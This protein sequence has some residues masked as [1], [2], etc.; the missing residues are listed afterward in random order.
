MVHMT[1]VV[2]RH[3]GWCPNARAFPAP[4]KDMERV[5]DTGS[6]SPGDIPAGG[7][8]GWIGRHGQTSVAITAGLCLF[9]LAVVLKNILVVPADVLNR[10]M[11][12][13]I[14]LYSG[15]IACFLPV[16]DQADPGMPGR[17]PLVWC[18]VAIVM[19]LA[20]IAVYSV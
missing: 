13:Y 17:W 14:I 18:A 20:I 8:T 12:L 11:V 19:T 4:Q 10:D 15:F 2:R 1:E 5:A 7:V 3:L 6:G 16:K 9:A